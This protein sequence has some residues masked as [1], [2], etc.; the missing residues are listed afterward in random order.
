MADGLK[1]NDLQALAFHLFTRCKAERAAFDECMESADKSSKCTEQYKTLTACATTLWVT[2]RPRASGAV[3]GPLRPG[4]DGSA[5][6]GSS[7]QPAAA[8]PP[9]TSRVP[10]AAEPPP[11]LTPPLARPPSR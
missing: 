6:A 11:Q 5:A 3:A 7:A 2:R 9:G 1:T 10:P 8:P 4:M